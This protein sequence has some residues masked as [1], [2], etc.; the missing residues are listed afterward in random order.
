MDLIKGAAAEQERVLKAPA[1]SALLSQFSA[2]GLEFTLV[3]WINDL[4]NGQGNLR[5]EVNLAILRA[6]RAHG[7]AIAP[8]ARSVPLPATAPPPI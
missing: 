7:I 3:Y 2:D 5:S 6:L 4:Q 8:S 1:P